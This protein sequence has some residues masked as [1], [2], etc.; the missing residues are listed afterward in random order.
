VIDTAG[1]RAGLSAAG[2]D[3]LGTPPRPVAGGDIAAAWRL[4]SSSGPLFLK[5]MPAESGDVLEVEAEGLAAIAATGAVRTPQVIARGFDGDTAWLALEWLEMQRL[6][7]ETEARLGQALAAM[8][9]STADQFGWHRDNRIGRTL[10]PNAW[11]DDWVGFFREHRLGFQLGLARDNGF[12]GRLQADGERLCHR[13]SALFEDYTPVASLLHGDLWA[14][15]A[16]RVSNDP[17]IFDPA[18]YYGDRESDIAMTRLFGG[19]GA[20]FYAAYDA[21]WPLDPGY[22]RR[23]P[24]YQL[25]HVL[26]HANLFGGGYATQA[27]RLIGNILSGL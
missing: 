23:E 27:E 21:A 19:Y 14:G 17:V 16:A 8:H 3:L 15:N 11:S 1:L 7:R 10:Q 4:E 6:D 22:G 24:L 2:V 13:L 18:V 12:R 25:Y 5:R 9:R 20:A 26:N